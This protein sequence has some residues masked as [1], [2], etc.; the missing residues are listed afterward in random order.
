MFGQSSLAIAPNL[1]PIHWALAGL[2]IA[3]VVLTLQFVA[4]RALGVST[5]LEDLCAL[6]SK[7]AYFARAELKQ[8]WRLA[9]MAGMLIGGGISAVLAGSYAVTWQV[10]YLDA[11]LHL[12]I[13]AKIVWFFVGG[14]CTGF[15]TRLAGGCTSGHGIYGM[16]RLQPASLITT[17]TFMLV[18]GITSN[19]LLRVLFPGG[20]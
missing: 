8:H 4:N 3:L 20:N 1:L 6:A 10:G 12:G 14:V 16:A 7:A 13:P 11:H 18:G 19:L 9:F 17:A 15:G 2:C 5:G